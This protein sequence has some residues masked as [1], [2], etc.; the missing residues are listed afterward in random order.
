[1]AGVVGLEPTITVLETDA[2]AAKLH[3]CKERDQPNEGLDTILYTRCI[4]SY[5]NIG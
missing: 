2:L 4:K 1:M 3:N 5:T